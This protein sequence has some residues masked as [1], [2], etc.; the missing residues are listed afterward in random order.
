MNRGETIFHMEQREREILF[1]I[2]K[3]N[4]DAI[5]VNKEHD[6]RFAQFIPEREYDPQTAQAIK[7][8]YLNENDLP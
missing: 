4:V 8:S 5:E 3:F 7:V 2:A 6:T 1:L